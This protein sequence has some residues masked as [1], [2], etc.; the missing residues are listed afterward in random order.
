[1]QNILE[2]IITQKKEDLKKIKKE[3]SL[4]SI[5]EKIKSTNN[6]LD[7]K[8]SLVNREQQNYVSL[9]G[10]IKKASPSAG[11]IVKD[12]DHVKIADLYS[13]NGVTCLSVLTEEN[14]F[15]GSLNY[16]EEIKKKINLPVLA[17]DFFIDPYQVSYSKS[18]GCDCILIILSALS[19]KQSDEI[20]DE[21][22]KNKLSVIVEVH[23]EKEAEYALKYEE[24]IIGINNRDLKS[25]NISL[26][27]TVRIQKK[28]IHHKGVLVSESGIK[29]KID[30]QYIYDKTGIKNFLIGESL[31]ASG[32]TDKLIKEIL[33]INL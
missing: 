2:K 6:Y 5:T 13:N 4:A 11:I 24:A 8:K 25:L 26:E 17:K 9:I 23:D 32:E 31:L 1:M 10:E 33:S 15:L 30:A 27:N 20:Y 18:F 12:F 29:N 28:L 21:A 22:L 14:F 3:N 19:K 7:F 16:I